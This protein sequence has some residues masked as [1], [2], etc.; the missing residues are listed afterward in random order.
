L[1]I[2]NNG[3]FPDLSFRSLEASQLPACISETV[4]ANYVSNFKKNDPIKVLEEFNHFRILC[5]LKEGPFGAKQINQYVEQ[6]LRRKGLIHTKERWYA[7]CPIMIT[8][9]D[10][11]LKLFNGDIGVLLPD[12]DADNKIRAFFIMPDGTLRK[13]LPNRLPEH[14]TV[15]AVTV[16]KSQGSEFDRVLMVLP[17]QDSPV[18]TRELVYTG[19][20]RARDYVEIW[21]T[22]SV[23]LSALSRRMQRSSGLRDLLWD[24][25]TGHFS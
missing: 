9:N 13:F 23:F 4:E 20:T 18:L 21:A 10:Y 15:Y 16:H 25:S 8:R 17:N 2:L 19:I 1:D 3:D 12:G 6:A 22:Q 11:R 14:E 24:F 5:A 7:G